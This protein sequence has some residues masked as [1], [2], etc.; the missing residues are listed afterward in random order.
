MLVNTGNESTSVAPTWM[1]VFCG[2]FLVTEG[3]DGLSVKVAQFMPR[4]MEVKVGLACGL[5][6]VI[7][8]WAGHLSMKIAVGHD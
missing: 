3:V 6:P 5:P 8:S 1:R 2:R 7:F 4:A